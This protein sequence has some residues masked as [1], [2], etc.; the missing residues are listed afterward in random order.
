M[1]GPKALPISVLAGALLVP[2]TAVASVMV[3]APNETP[4][5]QP[6]AASS[7]GPG[8][9]PALSTD[10]A[11]ACGPAG[12]ELVVLESRNSATDTQRA[13]LVA[14]RPICRAVGLALPEEAATSDVAPVV[15][16]PDPVTVQASITPSADVPEVDYDDGEYELEYEDG[17]Y[18]Y[19]YEDGEWEFD[20]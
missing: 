7:S 11:A 19:E 15:T 18:E 1:T 14:L 13:A 16:D 4:P 6:T 3:I 20:D 17:E 2:L 10:L 12:R 5:A 9:A 8:E